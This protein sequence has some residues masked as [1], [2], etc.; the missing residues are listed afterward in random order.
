MLWVGCASSCALVRPRTLPSVTEGTFC[1]STLRPGG[2][3]RPLDWARI[4]AL[5]EVP[6]APGVDELYTAAAVGALDDV[7]RLLELERAAAPPEQ[8]D[9][10]RRRILDAVGLAAHEVSSTVALL[11]CEAERARITASALHDA[12]DGQSQGFTLT[13]L[14][15]GALTAVVSGIVGLTVSDPLPAGVVGLAGGVLEGGLSVLAL[16]ANHTVSFVHA[17]NPLA[18]LQGGATH[19][20]FP[21]SVWVHLST[22]DERQP[23]PQRASARDG[24]LAAWRAA[25]KLGA[26][27]ETDGL[28]LGSGG[29]YGHRDLTQRSVMLAELRA[30]VA[31]FNQDLERF[32]RAMVRRP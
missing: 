13:A 26:S 5:S 15:L 17:T 4:Q 32:T 27:S 18:E 29:A 19:P 7:A 11:D 24:L 25:G 20:S 28:L 12:D 9:A 10:A 16:T 14:G 31:L 22:P 1:V 23:E 8:R 2:E 3:A 30:V 6:G 21:S